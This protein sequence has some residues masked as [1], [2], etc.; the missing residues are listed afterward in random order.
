[1]CVSMRMWACLRTPVNRFH[2]FNDDN[3]ILFIAFLDCFSVKSNR[4]ERPMRTRSKKKEMSMLI[5]FF[6]QSFSMVFFPRKQSTN[7]KAKRSTKIEW[8]QNEVPNRKWH[9]LVFLH[10]FIGCG[11][12]IRLFHMFFISSVIYFYHWIGHW[13]NKMF[14]NGNNREN[15]KL[16]KKK[17]EKKMWKTVFLL[18]HFGSKRRMWFSE[19]TFSSSFIIRAPP[20]CIQELLLSVV[21]EFILIFWQHTKLFQTSVSCAC[22]D[23]G[24][25]VVSTRKSVPFLSTNILHASISICCSDMSNGL[26]FNLTW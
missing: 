24:N 9:A 16:W 18:S 7:V 21:R 13:H 17:N 23:F 12:F 4:K 14:W 5:L 2:A 1:M 15:S 25:F 19:M 10:L 26:H 22:E 20:L 8:I 6:S 3:A 11:H